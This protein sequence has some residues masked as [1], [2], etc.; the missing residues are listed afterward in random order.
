MNEIQCIRLNGIE[1]PEEQETSWEGNDD[2]RIG[3]RTFLPS[4]AA[5][6]PLLVGLRVAMWLM[7]FWPC[8]FGN[9]APVELMAADLSF[10]NVCVS[11]RP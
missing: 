7:V 5:L 10:Y 8:H 6:L 4:S 9:F 11:G 1:C 2:E 3:F